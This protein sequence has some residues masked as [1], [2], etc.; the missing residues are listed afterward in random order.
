[1]GMVVF[2]ASKYYEFQFTLY[3][4]SSEFIYCIGL[5]FCGIQPTVS[6]CMAMA[7][8]DGKKYTIHLITLSYVRTTSVAEEASI[9]IML[10]K[11]FSYIRVW[12]S[13]LVPSRST[14]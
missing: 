4:T 7:K 8:S 6:T 13:G 1:M 11:R 14:G 10:R 5:L 2:G 12:D 3:N 9:V